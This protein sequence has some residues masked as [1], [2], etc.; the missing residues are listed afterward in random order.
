MYVVGKIIGDW[1]FSEDLLYCFNSYKN[2]NKTT[3]SRIRNVI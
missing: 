1:K 2:V 3:S